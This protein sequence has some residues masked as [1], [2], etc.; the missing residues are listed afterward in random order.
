MDLLGHRVE[1]PHCGYKYTVEA[2]AVPPQ[3]EKNKIKVRQKSQSARR[4]LRKKKRRSYSAPTIIIL[5]V[6][7][8]VGVY[9]SLPEEKHFTKILE[10]KTLFQSKLAITPSPSVSKTHDFTQMPREKLEPFLKT[11]CIECHGPKKQKG[12]LRFD[13]ISWDINNND[14]AQ[15]WQDILDQINSGDMPPEKAE[16]PH[17]SELIITLDTLTKG[18]LRARRAL[19]DHGGE[20]K[21]RRLN[22]RE[23]SN[24]I[25]QLFGF[26]VPLDEIPEDGEIEY[27]D[28]IGSE[29]FFTSNHFDKYLKLNR[30]IVNEAFR[31]S[32]AHRQKP[33]KERVEPEKGI[34]EKVLKQ[35]DEIAAKEKMLA[36]GKS[37]QEMGFAEYGEFKFWKDSLPRQKKWLQRT[38]SYPK[39]KSGMYLTTLRTNTSI[40]RHTD[41]RADYIL[42]IRGG[43]VGNPLPIRQVALIQDSNG[44]RATVGLRGTPENPET[45]EVRFRQSMGRFQ[46]GLT[47]SENLPPSTWGNVTWGDAHLKRLQGNLDQYNALWI[48]WLE[49]EGPFYPEKKSFF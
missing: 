8:A 38:L 43:V 10:N 14:T 4:G 31:H 18:M 44:T 20:I 49:L 3:K 16:Q 46:M 35:R 29:Q 48:D 27:F 25:Y 37:W 23:F 33:R 28:T 45:V 6:L 47:V 12:Q 21:M 19:T 30:K 41:I 32:I 26:D 39:F 36:E 24:I 5:I 11:Y 7:I 40:A 2:Q 1:C 34:I 9:F 15:L 13:T 17:K 42:R 22:R